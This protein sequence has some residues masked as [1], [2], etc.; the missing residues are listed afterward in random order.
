MKIGFVDIKNWS[1]ERA[2]FNVGMGELKYW[3][4]RILVVV[5]KSSIARYSCRCHSDG[6]GVAGGSPISRGSSIRPRGQ[7]GSFRDWKELVG[8]SI[9]EVAEGERTDSSDE[10]KSEA[11]NLLEEGRW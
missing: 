6:N 7:D 5:L 2:V 8:I 1:N 11:V 3:R 10:P 4:C 9:L